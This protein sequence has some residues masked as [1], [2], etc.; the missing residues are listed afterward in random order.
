[1][2]A[3]YFSL[4]KVHLVYSEFPPTSYRASCKSQK[5]NKTMSGLPLRRSEMFIASKPSSSGSVRKSG[6]TIPHRFERLPLFRTEELLSRVR[7]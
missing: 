5:A 3:T 7:L 6:M 2:C 1:M 4:S